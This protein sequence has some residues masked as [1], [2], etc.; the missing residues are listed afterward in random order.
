MRNITVRQLRYV[1]ALA[2]L[3]HFGRAASDCAVSQPALSV[4]VRELEDS[5]GAPLF[6]RGPR[7][8]RL[9]GFGAEFVRRTRAILRDIDELEDMARASRDAL[10]GQLRLGVIPT[11][12]PYLLPAI[13]GGLAATYPA[14]EVKVRETVTP[15]LIADLSDGRLD[16]AI[17][18]L[19]VPETAFDSAEILTEPFV[20]V[21]PVADAA[22]PVP[23]RDD[24]RGMRLLLLEEGHCFRDQALSFCD[25]R[26]GDT[27]DALDGSSLTTIV[28]MVAAGMGVTLIPEMA[29][30]VET[31][32]GDVV[33]VHFADP[34]PTRTLGMIWRRTSPLAPQLDQMAATV[35]AA[36]RPST[37]PRRTGYN[38]A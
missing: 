2:R 8:V 7:H 1:E 16:A 5:L 31:R 26:G 20:L 32:L 34:Q 22:A 9:S 25:M 21:R 15:T 37:K 6:E 10:A 11:V 30:P 33:A 17:L 12:A 36:V 28:Q 38:A 18:A 23:A 35:R 4:A 27:R 13:L 24:L 14:M 29:V 19:P 3:G